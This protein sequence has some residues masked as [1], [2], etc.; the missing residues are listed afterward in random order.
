VFELVFDQTANTSSLAPPVSSKYTQNEIVIPLD[1]HNVRNGKTLAHFT[2]PSI[3]VNSFL[4]TLAILFP[5][6]FFHISINLYHIAGV[7]SGISG[8]L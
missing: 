4:L 5:K 7:N 6:L 3:N 1:I 2:V 8:K